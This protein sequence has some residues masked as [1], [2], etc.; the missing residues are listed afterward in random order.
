MKILIV[1]AGAAGVTLARRILESS[2][3]NVV[4]LEHGLATKHGDRRRWL[5][6]VSQGEDPYKELLEESADSEPIGNSHLTLPGS[7]YFGV[8]GSTNAWGGWCLR[9]KPEDFALHTLTGQ[10]ADWPIRY[11]DLA[12]Y[13]D[14]AEK[15][16][17]VAGEEKPNPPLPFTLKDGVIIRAF[18]RLGIGDYGHLPLARKHG[19]VTIGTCKY[20]P[21]RQRYIPQSDL[22][23][24]LREY[25]ERA[26]LR[27]G[28]TVASL[29]MLTSSL[30]TGVEYLDQEGTAH[31]ESAD[32]IVL[33]NGAIEAP[34][35]LLASAGVGNE[36]GHV[37][38]HITAHPL[39]RVVGLR[40]GN[41]DNF[42]QPVDFPTL[43]CR[44]Y[45]SP[46][47]Q[48]QG[49][50]LFVRDGRRNAFSIEKG[51]REGNSLDT[52]R[53]SMR[54][55]MPF[56]LRGFIEVFANKSNYIQLGSRGSS[57][58]VYKTKISFAKNEQIENAIANAE[59]LMGTI[60]R[61]AGCDDIET[62]TYSTLRADHATSTC[63][64]ST[65][66]EDGVVD[67]DLRV[68]GTDN[69]YICSNAVMPNGGAANPT[70]TLIALTERLADHLAT[71]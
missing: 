5:D 67:V 69:L 55:K 61:E 36:F 30:C 70:L 19:C 37:G 29:T 18:G 62:K 3:S 35:L 12:P 64:M 2:E 58:G 41:P 48:A 63:R 7:R 43:V 21:V 25:P 44:H 34:K 42:E 28:V 51:L 39:L 65:R 31:T 26:E 23:T 52:I 17:W 56:E 8:G 32:V 60:L 14:R 9:Y 71:V 13:Y 54:E 38:R 53:V 66:P 10:G 20:C 47:Q 33:A 16:L 1:G 57:M 22:D 6:F 4:I 59:R 49:K 50:L 68:H 27:T 24:L 40:R 11:G 45:D 15:T 46:E